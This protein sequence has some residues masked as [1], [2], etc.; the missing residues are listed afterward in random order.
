MVVKA[1][2]PAPANVGNIRI[3]QAAHPVP[4]ASSVAAGAQLLELAAS[5]AADELLVAP[6]SGGGSALMCAPTRDLAT[7]AAQ[8]DAWLR[9]GVPIETIN[10]ERAK[11]DRLKAGGLAR[12]AAA[13]ACSV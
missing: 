5:V 7:L 11:H 3:V 13:D 9:E 1:G 6:I 2:T 4:D 10:A 12:A 8:T